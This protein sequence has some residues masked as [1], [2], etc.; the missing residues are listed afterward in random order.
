MRK[1]KHFSQHN[2]IYL[3]AAYNKY[4][5]IQS[6]YLFLKATKI[7]GEMFIPTS[8]LQREKRK[9]KKKI[10]IEYPNDLVCH[11]VSPNSFSAIPN[12]SHR[13]LVDQ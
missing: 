6:Y 10:Q 7:T 1:E 13:P 11:T 8:K 9:R 12:L 3:N 5:T 2:F 4:K